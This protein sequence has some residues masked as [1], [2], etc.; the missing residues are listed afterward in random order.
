M[1]LDEKGFSHDLDDS[2][3]GCCGEIEKMPI[4]LNENLVKRRPS[5][6]TGV[7]FFAAPTRFTVLRG[8]AKL[9][10]YLILIAKQ[11]ILD[12]TVFQ[13]SR[14]TEKVESSTN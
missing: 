12:L 14:D 2:F 13:A 3:F 8:L 6:A 9:K 4:N 10:E 7:R 5:S 11:S 1:L